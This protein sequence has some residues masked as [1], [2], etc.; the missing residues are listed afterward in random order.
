MIKFLINRHEWIYSYRDPF[1][2]RQNPRKNLSTE[3]RPFRFE[4][5]AINNYKNK[6]IEA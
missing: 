1:C 6:T 4:D 2:F 5:M 3:Y